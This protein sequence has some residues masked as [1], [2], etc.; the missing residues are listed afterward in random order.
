MVKCTLASMDHDLDVVYRL[1]NAQMAYQHKMLVN[2][3]LQLFSS[4]YMTPVTNI[5]PGSKDQQKRGCWLCIYSFISAG[6][7][8]SASFV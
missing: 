7:F 2:F 1:H 4:I 6:S 3:D 8:L 5:K